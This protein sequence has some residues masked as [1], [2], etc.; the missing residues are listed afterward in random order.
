MGHRPPI[1]AAI[2]VKPCGYT[3]A[4]LAETGW[5]HGDPDPNRETA[6]SHRDALARITGHSVMFLICSNPLASMHSASPAKS[7]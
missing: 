2:L 5:R 4:P 6:L 7:M 3:L 1:T